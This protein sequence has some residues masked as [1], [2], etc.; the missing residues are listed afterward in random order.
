MEDL[1]VLRELRAE[2]LADLTRHHGEE[3]AYEAGIVEGL[4]IALAVIEAGWPR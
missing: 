4:R 2:R 1:D 3:L